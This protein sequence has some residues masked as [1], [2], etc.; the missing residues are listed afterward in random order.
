VLLLSGTFEAFDEERAR[1][2]GAAGHVAKPFEAQWLVERVRQL[3]SEARPPA[4]TAGVS[5]GRV[6]PV[7]ATPAAP[8]AAPAADDQGF[9]FFEDE[10]PAADDL[11]GRSL[12][13]GPPGESL[14][15]DSDLPRPRLDRTVAILP[16]APP[17]G[18]RAPAGGAP[19][20]D[21]LDPG[22]TADDLMPSAMRAPA[23]AAPTPDDS[24]DFDIG[25]PLAQETVLDPKGASGFDVSSSDL[26]APD[27]EPP[28]AAPRAPARPA[29]APPPAH[30][31]ES[32]LT[33]PSSARP[34]G[35]PRA[36]P[37]PVRAPQPPPRAP[38][39]PPPPTRPAPPA[40]VDDLSFA[41]GEPD[42][43][44]ESGFALGVEEPTSA[45]DDALDFQIGIEEPAR[46]AANP[47]P[48]VK[49][50]PT[51]LDREPV[52]AMGVE[53]DR[54]DL[55]GEDDLEVLG[56]S[57]TGIEPALEPLPR[58]SAPHDPAAMAGVALAQVEP[59]LRD[60]LHDTLEKIAWEALGEVA[61]QIVRQTVERME[62]VA[63]EVIPQLAETLIRDEI[64][65]MK[66]ET[67]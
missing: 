39:P 10:A 6:N 28:R 54:G 50:P 41:I 9:D 33:P 17:A 26:G 55:V 21:A 27:L 51:R 13:L 58:V 47:R 38:Q 24:F 53:D 2:C 32:D 49:P 11:D 62:R 43:A 60:Q 22:S 4:P 29:P 46:P 65:R 66:G 3:F 16:D 37:P 40:P 48:A 44:G 30:E 20:H 12:D 19:Q 42:P 35:A 64:R 14:E 59:Q 56:Q 18:R 23:A 31:I 45:A 7:R 36:T 25:E 1:R 63:W 8:P 15:I 52:F 5:V 61:E 57:Q 67:D 34:A